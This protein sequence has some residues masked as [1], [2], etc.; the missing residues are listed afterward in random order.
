MT[1]SDTESIAPSTS[2][3]KGTR[4]RI[5]VALLTCAAVVIGAVAVVVWAPWRSAHSTQPVRYLGVAEP[6]APYS[7]AGVDQFAHAIGRQ[8]NLVVYYSPWLDPFQV[9]FA[10]SA[11]EHGAITLIQLAPKNVSLASIAAG[12]FDPYLRSYAAAVKTFGKQ[13]ILSFG[14]EM[15][16]NWYSWGYRHTSATVFVAAWQH[17]VTVFRAVGARN[18]TWL[19]TVNIFTTENLN[20]SDPASW[21]PGNSYVTWVGID[22]YYYTKS[23]TFAQIFGSTIVDVR[24]LTSDPIIIAETGASLA[25]GQSAKVTDLFSAVQAYDL[26]GFVWFDDNDTTHDLNWRLSS[27]AAMAY[28]Q[29]AQAFMEPPA[30]PVSTQHL[31]SGTS[32]P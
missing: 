10:T 8:P 27:S 5:L 32:S 18:V 21:W 7:Y 14:H 22:G 31:P 1:P 13:V 30:T 11:A 29:D 20:V 12:R 3:Q 9:S 16:G 28:R 2:R 6:D 19:W 25:A 4:F 17:I 15:N 26:L 23:Q 24:M